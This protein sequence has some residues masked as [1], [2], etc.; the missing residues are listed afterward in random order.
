MKDNIL[1]SVQFFTE[2]KSKIWVTILMSIIPMIALFG[3][4]GENETYTVLRVAGIYIFIFVSLRLLGKREFNQVNPVELLCLILIPDLVS[5][6]VVGADSTFM[7]SIVAVTT[8]FTL[9][10]ITSLITASS[11]KIEEILVG[12]PTILYHHGSHIKLNMEK[13]N[14]S[15]EDIL[16]AIRK[17]G[18]KDYRDIN[19]AVLETDGTI[20]I[21]SSKQS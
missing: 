10:S 20:S 3:L 5:Q 4:F 15:D 1:K 16:A 7:N 17:Q 11:K 2:R 12:C 8:L 13:E 18:L 6:G 21:I 14:I 19:M 9:V